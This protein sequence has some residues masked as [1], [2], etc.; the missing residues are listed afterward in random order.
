[1]ASHVARICSSEV[2]RV[3]TAS[4][5]IVFIPCAA[6]L[7]SFLRNSR[8]SIFYSWQDLIDVLFRGAVVKDAGS[9]C[10]PSAQH[11]VG[12]KYGAFRLHALHNFLVQRIERL[13]IAR[14][15]AGRIP[16]TND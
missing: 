7:R 1:M 15:F 11:A 2:T 12:K 6:P 13:F 16:K 3:I 10:K 14:E 9:Q 5:L 4:S 8:G